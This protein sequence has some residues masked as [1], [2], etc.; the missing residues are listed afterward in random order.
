MTPRHFH[1][2]LLNLGLVLLLV[3]LGGMSLHRAARGRFDFHHFYLDARYVW[4]HGELNPDLSPVIPNH[5]HADS[6]RQ[7]PFYLPVVALTLS[8]ITALGRVPA[9]I[10]W[11]AAQVAALG[12]SLR[13][14]RRWATENN[15]SPGASVA[16]ALAILLALP[17]LIEAA[18]FNQ[19]SYFV[20]ALV[21]GASSALDRRRP[22]TAGALLG[23]AAV[24][25][26]LPAIFLPWLLL[27]RRW[28]AA[29]SFVVASVAFTALPPLAVFGPH[30]SLEYH[31]QWW[32][33]NVRGDSAGGLLKT[34]LPD[35][36]ID[37]RNQSIV[38][39]LARL[40]WPEHPFA[41]PWR[42]LQLDR[43]A[44]TGLA[45]VVSGGLLL[46]LLLATRRPWPQLSISRC[47]AEM[48]VYAIG[49]LVFSP[50]LRQYYLVWAIPGLV[51]LAR[52]AADEGSRRARRLGLLGLGVW[53]VGMLAWMW[54]SARIV[55]AHLVMLIVLSVLL[56][57]TPRVAPASRRCEDTG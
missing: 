11:A 49:M 10:V 38:Q 41:V 46:A 17:A 3:V 6:V 4:E 16:F 56:L 35:H 14:L 55:G 45:Y 34:D 26:L 39:V 48:A 40:T 50:L 24:L 33:H 8:P 47:R 36:F 54:P 13:V 18:K 20:L 19:F 42:P 2:R 43:R 37:W 9:A 31:Q 27:K 7:L 1:D 32:E 52:V 57:W 12:Y 51:L 5:P 22:L 21:L 44:C 30:R 23:V 29:A 53:T 15:T 25:K 28:S